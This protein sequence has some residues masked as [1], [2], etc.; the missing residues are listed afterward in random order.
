MAAKSQKNPSGKPPRK[1]RKRI[2]KMIEQYAGTR[3]IVI[4]TESQQILRAALLAITNDPS[5]AWQ[6]EV[7]DGAAYRAT[8]QRQ[9]IKDLPSL[10]DELAGYSADRGLNTFALLH[11]LPKLLDRIFPFDKQRGS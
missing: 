5:P 7:D 3:N 9:L 11:S 4:S 8:L 1:T 10:L 6:I 2:N